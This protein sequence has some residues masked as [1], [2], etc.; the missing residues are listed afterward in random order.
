MDVKIKK[1]WFIGYLKDSS[2]YYFYFSTNQRTT[3]SKNAYFL[4]KEF[5]ED[6]GA[7]RNIELEEESRK[8]Q[9]DV[10]KIGSFT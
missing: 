1:G 2:G 7:K 8:P 5:L 6:N 4:K 3:V 10:I 9:T